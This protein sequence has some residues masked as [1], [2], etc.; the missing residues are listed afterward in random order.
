MV[1][2]D[3]PGVRCTREQGFEV[4]RANVHVGVQR[5]T[6]VIDLVPGD[7]QLAIFEFEVEVKGARF[8]GPFVHGQRGE[9]FLYLSWGEVSDGG[10]FTMFRRAKLQLDSLNAGTIDGTTIEGRLSMSDASGGPIG[11][12]VRPPAL[13]W[14]TENTATSPFREHS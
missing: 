10:E 3:M 14:V 8:T 9:R 1:G 12:S 7:A 13:T 2:T 5:G 6:S 4:D 11:A